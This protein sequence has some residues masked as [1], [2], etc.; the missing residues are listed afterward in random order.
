VPLDPRLAQ[1]IAGKLAHATAPQWELPIAEVRAGFAK[2]WTPAMTG[3]PVGLAGVES[4][5][6]PARAGNVPVRLYRPLGVTAPSLLM[7]CHGG[8]W[9]KGGLD[10]ADAFCRRLAHGTGR[11]VVAVGYRLAP[12]QPFPA[13]LDDAWDATVWAYG[14]AA[15]LGG[16]AR[17]FAVS[18]ESAGGNLAAVLSRLA[19]T[20]TEVSIS[21]QVL[22]QPVTDLTLSFP[23]IAMP[24]S[25]CLV[26]RADLDWY[27]R[28]YL[29]PGGDRRDPCVS[30]LW[31]DDPGGSPPALI[32]AAEYDSLRDEA[33]AYADK[34]RAAGTEVRY[35]CYPGMIHGFLQMAGLVAQAQQA[36]EEI[37]RFLRQDAPG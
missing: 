4:R 24:D 32:I 21:R 7:Y 8:G 22:L 17:A 13:A 5:A 23:S 14:H 3:E 15:E 12:E 28:Q 10:E 20:R 18:G 34:L 37:A 16:T 36:I 11:L 19:R 33:A 26:P 2:L 6:L 30:P 27:Y 31:A 29:G 35:S 1:L 9:V 25:E